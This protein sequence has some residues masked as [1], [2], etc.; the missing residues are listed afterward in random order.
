MQIY[1]TFIQKSAKNQY[2]NLQFEYE[3]ENWLNLHIFF[4]C[5]REENSLKYL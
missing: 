4:V 1:R 5:E 2:L 3:T